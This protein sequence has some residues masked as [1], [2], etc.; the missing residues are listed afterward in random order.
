[1]RLSILLLILIIVCNKRVITLH[2]R[3]IQGLWEYNRRV[4]EYYDKKSKFNHT[5]VE[6]LSQENEHSTR[7]PIEVHYAFKNDTLE[8]CHRYKTCY[9]RDK[10][11]YIIF[12]DTLKYY[13]MFDT[14]FKFP[15]GIYTYY[16]N[17][18][19]LELHYER[20][21]M[22]NEYDTHFFYSKIL[23]TFKLHRIYDMS[24]WPKVDCRM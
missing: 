18:D 11:R 12:N 21:F 19:T 8:I 13:L 14:T 15:Q 17:N 1:M 4:V 24:D 7:K 16:F 20:N 2:D 3:Q 10:F 9:V 5:T 6:T 23:G 22:I